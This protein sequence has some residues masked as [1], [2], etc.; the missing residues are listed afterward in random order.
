MDLRHERDKSDQIKISAKT[1]FR[2]W[3]NWIS[4]NIIYC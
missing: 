4:T 3:E 1:D 2:Y